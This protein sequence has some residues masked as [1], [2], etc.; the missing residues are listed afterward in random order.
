MKTLPATKIFRKPGS[1]RKMM[2][3]IALRLQPKI[4]VKPIAKFE[5]TAE[6]EI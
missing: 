2:M 1:D 5:R 6:A 4:R 3:M